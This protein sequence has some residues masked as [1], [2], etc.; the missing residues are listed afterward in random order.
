MPEEVT[1]YR[2]H[3]LTDELP[4]YTAKATFIDGD[5]KDYTYHE[6][7]V[8]NGTIILY[9]YD[10]TQLRTPATHYSKTPIEDPDTGEHYN[11]S[12]PYPPQIKYD[13]KLEEARISL[14]TCKDFTITYRDTQ[15]VTYNDWSACLDLPRSAAKA[16]AKHIGEDKC[17]ITP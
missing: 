14:A 12:I 11:E 3:P 2:D 17:R 9:K 10:T 15:T 8:K 5:T 6:K 7:Q 4:V 13:N 1:L 16:Y